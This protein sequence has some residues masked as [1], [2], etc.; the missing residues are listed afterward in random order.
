[1]FIIIEIS[2]GC[3][4]HVTSFS[5]CLYQGIS[6][7]MWHLAW[8]RVDDFSF[9]IFKSIFFCQLEFIILFPSLSQDSELAI[10][11]LV[12][13]T[14]WSEDLSSIVKTV[15][16]EP[17]HDCQA[18]ADRMPIELWWTIVQFRGRLHR[19]KQYL[20]RT[21]IINFFAR[22]DLINKI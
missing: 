19:I 2:K 22:I 10:S 16:V 4:K 15:Y 12:T 13:S 18:C 20:S 14:W 7:G 6:H 5:Y 8:G 21:I 1:M 3:D 17:L 11:Y 9:S